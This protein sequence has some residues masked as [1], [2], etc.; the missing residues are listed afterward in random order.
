MS[1]SVLML[2]GPERS[3]AGPSLAGILCSLFVDG[4]GGGCCSCSSSCT[5]VRPV[6]WEVAS[7]RGGDGPSQDPRSW[8]APPLGCYSRLLFGELSAAVMVYC[9]VGDL[10]I[11]LWMS[12]AELAWIFQFDGPGERADSFQLFQYCLGDMSIVLPKV[13]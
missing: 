1:C 9:F 10:R 13:E 2:G 5:D 8:A 11:L 3:S 6:C 7:T 4:G 12:G